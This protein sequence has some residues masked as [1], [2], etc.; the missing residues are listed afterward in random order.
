[1]KTKELVG[2]QYLRAIAAMAVVIDHAAAMTAFPKYFGVMVAGGA[3]INGKLGV[4]IFFVVSGFIITI[5]A[6]SGPSLSGGQGQATFFKKRFSR[7]IPLMWTSIATYFILRALFVAENTDLDQYTNAF[8]LLPWGK[9]TPIQIWTLR[10]E[11]IFYIIFA[12]TFLPKRQIKF[13]L[14]SW[15]ISP[16]LIAAIE[17]IRGV[18]FN[19]TS[20][21]AIIFNRHNLEFGMGF[22]IGVAKLRLKRWPEIQMPIHPALVITGLSIL[23]IVAGAYAAKAVS[24]LLATAIMGILGGALV[25]FAASVACSDGILN[26]IFLILGN[27]SYA[28]YLFHLHALS[29]C[30]TIMSKLAPSMNATAVIVVLA[31]ISAVVGIII[32]K[33]LEVPL[34]RFCQGWMLGNTGRSSVKPKPAH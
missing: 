34:V 16:C 12:L 2:V 26:R 25:F 33:T 14:Y 6:L 31:V 8:F 32:H 30:L 15:F 18:E 5:V 11:F 10:H 23:S 21:I 28:I 20:T 17:T 19:K 4:D 24:P 1:M 29:A 7:I 27:A 3:L 22:L 13:I 9:V